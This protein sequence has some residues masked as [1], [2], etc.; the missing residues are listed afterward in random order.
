MDLTLTTLWSIH[1]V[2]HTLPDCRVSELSLHTGECNLR[3]PGG[4]QCGY[5]FMLQHFIN[6]NAHVCKWTHSETVYTVCVHVCA[7]I[8]HERHVHSTLAKK[9]KSEIIE[10]NPP[11]STLHTQE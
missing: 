1:A 8:L 9:E 11:L 2:A 6:I 10:R 4:N 3:L 5:V 7:Y